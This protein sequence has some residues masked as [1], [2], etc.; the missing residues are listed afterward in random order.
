LFLFENKNRKFPVFHCDIVI[1]RPPIPASPTY[2]SSHPMPLS[3]PTLSAHTTTHVACRGRVVVEGIIN[4]VECLLN[5]T[6]GILELFFQSFGFFNTSRTAFSSLS[7]TSFTFANASSTFSFL[8]SG[9][10]FSA[11]CMDCTT[12]GNFFFN[13]LSSPL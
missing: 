7:T 8:S 1:F 4:V 10:S 5:V 13:S 3:A 9:K 6:G 2:S 12:S 11:F